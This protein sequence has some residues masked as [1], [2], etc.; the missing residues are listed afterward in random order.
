[1]HMHLHVCI[2]KSLNF[3][4]TCSFLCIN[5][6]YFNVDSTGATIVNLEGQFFTW[7]SLEQLLNSVASHQPS[8][9]YEMVDN[10]DLWRALV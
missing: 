1:M 10:F 4:I 6:V 7:K 2:Y 9:S 5:K 3:H 8:P